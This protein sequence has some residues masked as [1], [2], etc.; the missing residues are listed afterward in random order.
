MCAYVGVAF[1]DFGLM[2]GD[3]GVIEVSIRVPDF[4]IWS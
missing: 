1:V 2:V 3:F 4:L